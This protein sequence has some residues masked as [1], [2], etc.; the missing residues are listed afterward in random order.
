MRSNLGFV[1]FTI[2]NKQNL[3][4][5]VNMKTLQYFKTVLLLSM[6]VFLTS[7]LDDDDSKWPLNSVYTTIGEVVEESD[8]VYYID[9]DKDNKLYVQNVDALKNSEIENGDRVYAEFIFVENNTNRPENGSEIKVGFIYKVLTKDIEHL[10]NENEY[11]IGDDNI[12]V[13]NIWLSGDY[14]NLMY[15]FFTDSKTVHFLNMVTVDHP[16]KAEDGYLYLEF[17]HNANYDFN[18]V[19]GLY[20]GLVSF[21]VDEIIRQNPGMKGFII[22]VNRNKGERFYK[23]DLKNV[24]EDVPE[25]P[26][27]PQPL[28][29]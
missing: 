27:T 13:S 29:E 2:M 6:V 16:K 24:G 22:R 21:D 8:D 15:S 23:V 3:Y 20:N 28:A 7:C 10:S 25:L 12:D 26:D 14:L 11:E 18:E 1:A 4:I 19:N 5:T 17:R 9:S